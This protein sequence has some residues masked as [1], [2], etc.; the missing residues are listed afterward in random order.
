ICGGAVSVSFKLVMKTH[1]STGVKKRSS[2]C[3][4]IVKELRF[5]DAENQRAPTIAVRFTT[6]IFHVP[7]IGIRY[8]GIADEVFPVRVVTTMT[9]CQVMRTALAAN[10]SGNGRGR[11]IESLATSNRAIASEDY[12]FTQIGTL[13]TT[14]TTGGSNLKTH[15]AIQ[16][17]IA[18]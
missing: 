3:R 10:V 6:D 2:I 9:Q 15:R 1:A 14:H 8:V 5:I 17:D 13:I 11:R 12:I 4:H 18:G 7:T 16:I